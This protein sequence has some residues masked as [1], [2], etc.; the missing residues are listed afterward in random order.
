MKLEKKGECISI[1]VWYVIGGG[2]HVET[3]REL[4]LKGDK[5][6]EWPPGNTE[7]KLW[8]IKQNLCKATTSGQNGFD[9]EGSYS[10]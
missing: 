6:K 5:L 10:I 1:V 8:H 2:V 7:S 3:A 9:Q 4:C